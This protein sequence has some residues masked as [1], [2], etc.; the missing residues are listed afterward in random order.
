MLLDVWYNSAYWGTFWGQ[1]II[2]IIGGTISALIFLFIVL[3][4]IRP[5]VKIADFFCEVTD[6][7]GAVYYSF[8]FVNRSFFNSHHA[9]VELYKMRRIP[10]GN[11]CYN[12]ICNKIALVTGVF[13]HVPGR[14]IGRK[15]HD[16]RHCILIRSTENIKDILTPEENSILLKISL[17]HGLTG[18]SGV[19]E[20]EYASLSDIKR[21]RFKPGTKFGSM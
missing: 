4:F 8:K 7:D 1:L 19:F 2:E 5:K 3:F 17:N 12:N 9:Q 18:L 6:T 15:T 13:N 10:M 16:N 21:G 20:Q 11:G 14:P